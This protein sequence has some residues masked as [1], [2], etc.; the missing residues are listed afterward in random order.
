MSQSSNI[1][2]CQLTLNKTFFNGSGQA[3]KV[4]LL[5]EVHD[6]VECT[7]NVLS[8]VV[9]PSD[10]INNVNLVSNEEEPLENL[11]TAHELAGL[12]VVEEEVKD[13]AKETVHQHHD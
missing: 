1:S 2:L 12:L 8:V 3:A 13:D 6:P 5:A 4:T 11:E 7:D 10:A 9:L